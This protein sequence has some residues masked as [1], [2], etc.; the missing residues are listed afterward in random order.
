MR[1][2]DGAEGRQAQF[3]LADYLPFWLNAVASKWT[4]GTTRHY[5]AKFDLGTIEWRVLV[6]LGSLGTAKSFEISNLTGAEISGVCKA[7]RKL[8]TRSLV[9]AISGTSPFRDKP[10]ALTPAG[11][12]LLALGKEHALEMEQRLLTSLDLEDQIQ[13]LILLQKI[14]EHPSSFSGV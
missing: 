4:A 11:S 12:N 1:I 2:M 8:E 3:D 13:L 9:E 6:A 10:F 5:R 7:L 14:H